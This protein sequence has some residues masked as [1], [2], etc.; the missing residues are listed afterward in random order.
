MSAALI[1]EEEAL[2][3]VY[4]RRLVGRLWRY[5]S[6]YRGQV[7][8]TLLMVVPLF[9]VELAPAWIIK[10]GLDRAMGSVVDTRLAALEAWLDPPRGV[11][12]WTWLGALYLAAMLA[13]AA[14]QYAH[15]LLMAITGESAM[16][17]LRAEIFAHLQRLHLGFFDRYPV[18]RLVT[19]ATNDVENV[20]EMFSAGIVLLITDVL[21]MLGILGVLFWIDAR[22]ALL[23]FLVVPGLAGVAVVLRWRIREAFRNVRVR[24][25]RINATV[26]ETVTGMKVVQLF[27]REERNL[28]DFDEQ[29][30]GH[31]DAWLESI[32]YDAALFAAVEVANYLTFAVIIGAGWSL[33]SLGTIYLFIDWMRR[34]FMPLRDLS[35]KFSVMQSAMASSERIFQL[36]DT[37][38]AIRDS[39]PPKRMASDGLQRAKPAQVEFQNVWFAYHGEDWVLRDVSFRVAAG[40][41]VALV[42]ATGAGKTSIIKLL[43]RLYEVNRGRILLDGVDLREIP[44]LELRRRVAMVLQDVFLFSGSVASNIGLDRPDVDA[45]T[46]ERAARAVE[47]ERFIERLPAGYQTVLRERG[48][49]L[50]AGQR[51]LLSFARALAHGAG[52]LVLDEATSS[53]DPET[54]LLVQDGIRTL[55]EH[56]TAIVVAHRLST[57]QDVDRIHVLHRGRIVESGRHAELMAR[58]GAYQRLYRLQFERPAGIRAAV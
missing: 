48:S 32:R 18:G 34:F 50:S 49:E 53:V 22:L 43:T 52:L 55:M 35:A 7:V 38:P 37:K 25:A 26:Q 30:A 45:A 1:H 8:L 56:Q 13:S 11:S 24:I 51:Q 2:G 16:R 47:A 36:L 15:M 28:R 40:E 3:R 5:V 57:I 9:A 20:S 12:P 42:G 6:P 10:T 19:R 4:D 14:L 39:V 54:E 46:I 27:T 44:Q 33:V 58:G 41:R 31:R 17:D 29:N 23:T 21:K